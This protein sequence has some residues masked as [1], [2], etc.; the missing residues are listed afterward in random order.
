M[1]DFCLVVP[2]SF[3]PHSPSIAV[4]Y[5][6]MLLERSQECMDVGANQSAINAA[7]LTDFGSD[8][9]FGVSPG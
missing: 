1:V 6:T 2:H 5:Q 4:H 9:I 3:A 8:T 7:P